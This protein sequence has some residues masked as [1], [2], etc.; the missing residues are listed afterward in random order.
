MEPTARISA[1][2]RSD[3]ARDG[4]LVVPGVVDRA[5]VDAALQLI[6][7]WIFCEFDHEKRVQ[8]YAQSFAT[9]RQD[10]PRILGLLH[11]TPA[12]SLATD[13]VGRRLA[14]PDKGQ[15]ALRFP[16]PPDAPPFYVG[17][18]VD[19]VPTGINGVPEDGAIHGFT[20]N[21]CVLLSDLTGPDQ[22]NFTVWPGTHLTMARWFTEHGARIPDPEVFFRATEDVA[23][24]TSAPYPVTGRAGDLI[25]AHHLTAH[26]NGGHAGPNIRYA[27]FFRLTSDVRYD[28]GDAVYTDPWA[29]WDAMR[30]P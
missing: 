12:L 4:F 22:G 3:F 10:D 26:A 1:E 25:L 16:V 9:D 5:R 11:D 21:A 30:T 24:A 13:L 15:V 29:E 17:A 28:L 2:Q 18:H 19:G 6:N 23:N 7:H 14:G 27:V 20:I 8:Y